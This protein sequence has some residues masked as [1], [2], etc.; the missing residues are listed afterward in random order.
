MNWI[1]AIKTYSAKTGK[2]YKVPKKGT[3]E[4]TAIKK[5]QE[6]GK[7]GS[8]VKEVFTKVA[9]TVNNTIDKTLS[10]AEENVPLYP[11]EMHAKKII[12]D[13]MKL[14]YK[15]YNYAGPG[16]AVEKRLEL[17]I[18]PIDGIDAAAKQHDMDY[19]LNFQARAKKGEKV[20]KSEV[21]AADKKFVERAKANR[22]DNPALVAA[23]VPAFAAKKLA[24]DTGIMNSDDFFNPNKTG[25]GIK[26]IKAKK[27][28]K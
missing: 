2:P 6:N 10:P 7:K 9:K 8:G 5:I 3:P 14:K 23:I 19:T 17:G 20:S 21:Q 12:R 25:S 11:G 13:G 22:K 18:K 16:T 27:A 26:T 15:N 4:Y 1:E 28:K 24:E